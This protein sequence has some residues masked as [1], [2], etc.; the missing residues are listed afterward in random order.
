MAEIEAKLRHEANL[1]NKATIADQESQETTKIEDS[2]NFVDFEEEDLEEEIDITTTTTVAP[3][4]KHLV[5]KQKISKTTTVEP[6]SEEIEE[7]VHIKNKK[8]VNNFQSFTDDAETTVASLT[9]QSE[10]KLK[11]AHRAASRE[12]LNVSVENSEQLTTTGA[13][14]TT[15]GEAIESFSDSTASKKKKKIKKLR[16]KPTTQVVE[17]TTAPVELT[18]TYNPTTVE[19]TTLFDVNDETTTEASKE[20]YTKLELTRRTKNKHATT[21]SPTF[22]SV[23]KSI[24][25]EDVKQKTEFSDD[26]I[27]ATT[28]KPKKR[29]LPKQQTTTTTTAPEGEEK[30][31]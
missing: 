1:K 10:N 8:K 27:I 6:R 30:Y 15:V 23:E 16:L 13:T 21:T 20:I 7:A 14:I 2:S 31:W 9:R 22:A 11:A 19:A 29:R 4:K 3:K 12:V 26:E 5:R 25:A 28:A 24:T 18:P 17:E